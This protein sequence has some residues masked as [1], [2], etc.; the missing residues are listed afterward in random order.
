MDRSSDIRSRAD[1]NALIIATFCQNHTCHHSGSS[2]PIC[3]RM[4]PSHEFLRKEWIMASTD[5]PMTLEELARLPNIP[6]GEPPTE[7]RVTR[8]FLSAA[9]GS[10]R[11]EA[12]KPSGAAPEVPLQPV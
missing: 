9:H 5:K 6:D 12:L 2:K 8:T 1:A 4:N 10:G 7:L 11:R 3:I